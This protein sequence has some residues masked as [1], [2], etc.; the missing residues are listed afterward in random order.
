MD[1]VR[2]RHGV[3]RLRRR[4][5]VLV[6]RLEVVEAERLQLLDEALLD[7]GGFDGGADLLLLAAVLA[8]FVLVVFVILLRVL[9]HN[10]QNEKHKRECSDNTIRRRKHDLEKVYTTIRCYCRH[11]QILLAQLPRPPISG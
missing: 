1:V 7:F 11:K 8:L 5:D 3:R 9:E 4:L 2:Q 10:E 6:L